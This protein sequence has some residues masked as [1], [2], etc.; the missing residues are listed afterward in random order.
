MDV[1]IIA[2]AILFKKNF[3]DVSALQILFHLQFPLINTDP[4]IILKFTKRLGIALI[5]FIIAFSY[6]RIFKKISIKIAILL[7][8]TCNAFMCEYG[9]YVSN[10]HLFEII[11]YKKDTNYGKFY[12]NNYVKADFYYKSRKEAKPC[13]DI[14]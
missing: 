9:L 6:P 14:C 7:Y 1:F 2:Y 8:F 4:S 13:I 12:E 3:G 11:T 10:L 5:V